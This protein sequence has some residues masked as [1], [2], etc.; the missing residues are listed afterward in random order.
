[1][2]TMADQHRYSVVQ[3]LHYNKL[4]AVNSLLLGGAP[5][6]I[7]KRRDNKQVS[8]FHLVQLLICLIY[9]CPVLLT[10]LSVRWN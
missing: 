8:Q 3:L 10:R 4:V 5:S 9:N 1:M 2:V 6:Q 7:V